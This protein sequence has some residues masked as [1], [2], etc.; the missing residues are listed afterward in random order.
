[1]NPTSADFFSAALKDLPG[2]TP[3][4]ISYRC[5]KLGLKRNTVR[6]RE[7]DEEQLPSV[8]ESIAS[9][10][11]EGLS[12][13]SHI[14]DEGIALR[15]EMVKSLSIPVLLTPPFQQDTVFHRVL[16]SLQFLPPSREDKRVVWYIPKSL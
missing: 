8:E 13:L 10:H 14:L 1:M 2:R 3:A 11:P 6:D 16:E 5:K 7:S 9:L 12:C 4:Q 15:L